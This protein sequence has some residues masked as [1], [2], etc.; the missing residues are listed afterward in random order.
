[1]NNPSTLLKSLMNNAVTTL[2]AKANTVLFQHTNLDEIN[3][4]FPCRGS[5]HPYPL[6]IN[7]SYSLAVTFLCHQ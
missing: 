4:F 2:N 5:L 7:T 1:M 3:A 6:I